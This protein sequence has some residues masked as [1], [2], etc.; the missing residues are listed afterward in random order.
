MRLARLNSQSLHLDGT[1]RVFGKRLRLISAEDFYW[2]LA[3][4][5]AD[6]EHVRF[7]GRADIPEYAR[8]CPL[9]T[10][11]G[12]LQI[13]ECALSGPGALPAEVVSVT[14]NAAMAHPA[15]ASLFVVAPNNKKLA[16]N[17]IASLR[18]ESKVRP[19]LP[20]GGTMRAH[21]A[22]GDYSPR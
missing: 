2:H 16:R 3:D 21:R 8:Q 20:H 17:R 13:G 19:P 14:A 5:D 9:M 18:H 4:I 7:G 6:D 12:H 22:G 1:N 15:A 11:S 10:H